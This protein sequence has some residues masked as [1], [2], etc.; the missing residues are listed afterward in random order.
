MRKSRSNDQEAR[1]Q[2]F[3]SDM[4]KQIVVLG[5]DMPRAVYTAMHYNLGWT[6]VAAAQRSGV[7]RRYGWRWEWV[8]GS[9]SASMAKRVNDARHE[10]ERRYARNIIN[11]RR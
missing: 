9:P 2:Q 10:L 8:G 6:C 4:H 1:V 3:L 7:I 11:A 5:D